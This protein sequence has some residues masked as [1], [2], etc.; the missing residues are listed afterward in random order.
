MDAGDGSTNP[1]G[2]SKRIGGD[3][4]PIRPSHAAG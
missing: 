3:D 2:R 4:V 1:G